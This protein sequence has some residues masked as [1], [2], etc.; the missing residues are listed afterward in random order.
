MLFRW[1]YLCLLAV[2]LSLVCATSVFSGEASQ[3]SAKS[4]ILVE[5]PFDVIG[6]QII[7][8]DV[9][10]NDQGPY[11]FEFDTGA[12]GDGRVDAALAEEQGLKP[13]G[14]VTASDASYRSG[15]TLPLYQINSL[16]VG[17]LEFKQLEFLSRDYN[18]ERAVAVRGHVHGILGIGLFADKLVTIDYPNKVLTIAEGVLPH[19]N[20]QTILA[21]DP[22]TP[23]LMVQVE[24]GGSHYAAYVDSGAM[25][26]L[27]V[28]E[29]IASELDFVQEP[30]VV[31]RAESVAGQFEISMGV[32]DGAL[33][34]GD[35]T[36]DSPQVFIAEAFDHV[37]LGAPLL[38]QFVISIDQ[39]NHRIQ[40]LQKD[41]NAETAEDS[42][43]TSA[44]RRSYGI[45]MA[46]P[47]GRQKSLDILGVVDGGIAAEKGLLKGDQ[48]ISIN[49]QRIAQ[50]SAQE[51]EKALRSSPLKLQLDR[52]GK[53]HTITL[54]W[55][56]V[57]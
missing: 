49:D 1:L 31:G 5:I 34:F 29:E 40:F 27:T 16:R 17:G 25:P 35:I 44:P 53:R 9:W 46:P 57:D 11:R 26:N 2:S 54:A 21:L 51:I 3:T 20:G 39:E 4:K 13:S 12:Q 8:D 36:L 45:M 6:T 55:D 33:A 7:I 38:S 10:L 56:A 37:I 47:E 50:S 23:V 18:S 22:N 15:P 32:L 14:E 42:K 41:S 52:K 19:V 24:L 48:I 43:R 30:T 28:S